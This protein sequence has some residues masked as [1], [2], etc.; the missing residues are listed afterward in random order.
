M[1]SEPQG[2]PPAWSAL[3]S[4]V[5]KGPA[6]VQLQADLEAGD[7]SLIG[8]YLDGNPAAYGELVRRHQIPLFRLLLGLLADEDLA[9]RACG[10]VF[11]LA[12]RRLLE[13]DDRDQFY[14]WLLAI[15]REVAQGFDEAARAEAELSG[16]V[17]SPRERL[18]REVHAVLQELDPDQRLVLVMAEL[19]GAS[20]AEIAAALGCSVGEVAAQVVAARAAFTEVMKARAAEDTLD[21]PEVGADLEETP[22]LSEGQ[23]VAGR[24]EI[25]SLLG[26]GGMGAV[27]L[28]RRLDDG[29]QVA[30]KTMLPGW[31]ASEVAVRRFEREAEAIAR[32]QHP[33]FV[34][35]LD[36]GRTEGGM[37]YLVMELL[38]GRE[39]R[40]VFDDAGPL[41]P[42]RALTLVQ[43][44]LA[45]LAAAHEA[46]VVHRDLKPANVFV[47]DPEGTGEQPKVLDLGLAKLVSSTDEE[48]QRTHLTQQGMVFGTPA[49]MAPEQALGREV[50]PR[51]DL[52]AVTVM[53]FELLTGRLPFRAGN[54][55]ALLVMHVSQAAPT[56]AEVAPALA[57]VPGLQVLLDGGF[58]KARERRVASARDYLSGI[59]AVLEQSL[60]GPAP[61]PELGVAATQRLGVASG[62]VQATEV[63]PVSSQGRPS[64]RADVEAGPE[65]EPN[66]PQTTREVEPA[67]SGPSMLVLV[68]VALSVA[69]LVIWIAVGR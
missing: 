63:L 4:S 18:K 46:G 42:R 9:E 34:A 21:D 40:E 62:R 64:A 47:T 44:V 43:A 38:S 49:Y 50:D 25:E 16:G 52:Y 17:E 68:I 59:E 10:E 32:V 5:G 14:C 61:R 11:L 2:P 27:Y 39:L 23:V 65:A 67:A 55:S 66:P 58:A 13:L 51:V 30:L 41:D 57:G 19:R 22:K 8:A 60:P 36:H 7:A 1:S 6:T 53:L 3:D 28:A 37:P 45:G 24:Y 35:I 54:A 31:V 12:D 56:L 48:A 20:E 29:R 15:T 69:A 33:N 26:K